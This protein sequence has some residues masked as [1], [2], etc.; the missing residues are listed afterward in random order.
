MAARDLPEAESDVEHW[1]LQVR[2][3]LKRE[4]E[5]ELDGRRAYY[6]DYLMRHG[7]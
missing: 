1:C 6:I 7:G 5:G 4:P 2:D 3:A